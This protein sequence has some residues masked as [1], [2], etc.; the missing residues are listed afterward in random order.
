MHISSWRDQVEQMR[1]RAKAD[2]NHTGESDYLPG[3]R[4]SRE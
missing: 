4:R 2:L 1:K 3:V